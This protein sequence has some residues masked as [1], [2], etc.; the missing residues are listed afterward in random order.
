[1]PTFASRLRNSKYVISGK[2]TVTA[3]NEQS[4]AINVA[5]KKKSSSTVTAITD[6]ASQQAVSRNFIFIFLYLFLFCS[7]QESSQISVQHTSRNSKAK[8][9]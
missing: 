5:V 6:S 1:M 9:N 4:A 7:E 8:K 3:N 2:Q